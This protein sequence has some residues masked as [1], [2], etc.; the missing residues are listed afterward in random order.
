MNFYYRKTVK[1]LNLNYDSCKAVKNQN[2]SSVF[3]KVRKNQDLHEGQIL[4]N[5]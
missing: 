4:Q 5:S 3:G 1:K 2:I